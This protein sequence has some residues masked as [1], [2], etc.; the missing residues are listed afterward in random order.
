[1][2]ASLSGKV[3]ERRPDHVVIECGGVGFRVAVSS[4]TLSQ[5]PARGADGSL[6]FWIGRSKT[7]RRTEIPPAIRFDLV[8]WK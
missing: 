6:H 3:A 8:E 7:P 2:I 5:V 4:Q 1:M